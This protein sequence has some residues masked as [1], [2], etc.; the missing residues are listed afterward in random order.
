MGNENAPALGGEPVKVQN[1]DIPL[2]ADIYN[3]MQDIQGLEE[4]RGWQAERMYHIT[5][6]LSGMPGG[7]T[8][9][10][11]DEAFAAL[12]E[13]DDEHKRCCKTYVRQMRK[14]QKIL[15]SIESHTMRTFVTMKYVM[16]T[17]DTEIRKKMHMSRRGFERARKCIETAPCM[18][19]V[20]WQERYILVS[21]KEDQKTP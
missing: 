7:G 15:R 18:A 10:G 11:L 8:P 13:I 14:A 19:A 16:D 21:E 2:L 17:P 4:R 5:Q 3:I 1:R 9:K 6:Y 20:K 12:A